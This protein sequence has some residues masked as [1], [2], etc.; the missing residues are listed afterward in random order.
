MTQAPLVVIYGSC[1]EDEVFG[2][3]PG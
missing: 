2:A 3:R 1:L